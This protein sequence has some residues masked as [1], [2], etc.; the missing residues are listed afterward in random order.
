MALA[1]AKTTEF[2]A[3][4]RLGKKVASIHLKVECFLLQLLLLQKREKQA[5]SLLYAVSWRLCDFLEK[6]CTGL[7]EESDSLVASRYKKI[8]DYVLKHNMYHIN[9]STDSYS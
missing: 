6:K 8:D 3:V 5:S 9:L 1:R 4:M 2:E 7:G